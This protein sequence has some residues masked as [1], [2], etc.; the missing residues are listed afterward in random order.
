MMRMLRWLICLAILG[1]LVLV[2]F[3]VPIGGKTVVER[4]SDKEDGL[5]ETSSGGD[6]IEFSRQAREGAGSDRLTEKDREDL[7]KLI[8]SKLEE[9]GDKK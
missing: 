4:F 3:T 5:Q 9:R 8:E 7:D 6:K 1:G 2:A